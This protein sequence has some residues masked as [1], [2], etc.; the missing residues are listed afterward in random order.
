[1][2]NRILLAS[3]DGMPEKRLLRALELE[4]VQRGATPTLN[5]SECGKTAVVVADPN[6]IYDVDGM[7]ENGM[8]VFYCHYDD[9]EV[10]DGV[11]SIVRPFSLSRL[12]D[13]VTKTLTDLPTPV[14]ENASLVLSYDVLTYGE[15]RIELS[16]TEMLLFL[17]LYENRGR[18]VSREILHKSVWGIG[19]SNVL[20]VYISYLRK[21]LDHR[22]GKQ[23]ICT[24]RGKGYMLK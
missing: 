19:E 15:E 4:L 13:T 11:V 6:E 14:T 18:P 8:T 3:G 2:M 12:V 23:F 16:Q 9:A 5:M 24:V 21:K 17:V 20:D 7:L 1:M 10:P 22:F